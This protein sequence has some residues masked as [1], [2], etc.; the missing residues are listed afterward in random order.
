MNT[1][2]NTPPDGDFARLVEQ[3]AAEASRPKRPPTA[4]EHGLDV[5][6]TPSQAPHGAATPTAAPASGPGAV[7]PPSA[8]AAMRKVLIGV[9]IG[10]VVLLLVLMARG[11]PLAVVFAI[12][13]GGIAV[14]RKLWRRALPPGAGGM[15]EW[16]E[17]LVKQQQERRR[18]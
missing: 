2:G 10:W 18:K 16:R 6:M 14:V 4:T 7:T 12:L 8:A 13:I 11:A 3:L 5:G 15:R 9:A 1:Q 17:Q